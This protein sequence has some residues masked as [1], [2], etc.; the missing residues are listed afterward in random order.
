MASDPLIAARAEALFASDL[1]IQ[2]HPGEAEAAAAIRSVVRAHGGVRGC[3]DEDV[4]RLPRSA[5]A[6]LSCLGRYAFGPGPS[7]ASVDYATRTGATTPIWRSD[8]H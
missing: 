5:H 2:C 6:H 4:A 8:V 3:A 7:T 1:S